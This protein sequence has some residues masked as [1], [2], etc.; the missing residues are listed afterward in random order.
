LK[1]IL[2]IIIIKRN[3]ILKF[4]CILLS[5]E[6]YIRAIEDIGTDVGLIIEVQ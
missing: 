6:K 2:I 5:Q 4:I 3:Y 1:L